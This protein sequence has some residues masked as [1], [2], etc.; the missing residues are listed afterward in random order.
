MPWVAVDPKGDWWGIRL[1]ADGIAEGLSVPVFG[2]LH[3]DLPLMPWMGATIASLIVDYNLTCVLDVSE[4]DEKEDL[5]LF[6]VDFM[7]TLYG[8]HGKTPSPRHIF[9]EEADAIIPQKPPKDYQDCIRWAAKLVRLGRSRGLGV[10]L[11]SQR[12]AGVDK[13]ALS[14][15][16][17]IIAMRTTGTLDRKAIRDWLEHHSDC[18]EIVDSLPKLEDGEAWICSPQWLKS[19]ERVRFRRR[20]TFD[21][22]ATPAWECGV[23]DQDFAEVDIAALALILAPDTTPVSFPPDPD[24][25]WD[26]AVPADLGQAECDE[27]ELLELA[28]LDA[29][30]KGSDSPLTT[31]EVGALVGLE[32]PSGLYKLRTRLTQLEAGGHVV[33]T[34][35]SRRGAPS[36]WTLPE[37]PD[38]VLVP[39][40]G[41]DVSERSDATVEA[42][43]GT[44]ADIELRET[45]RE[46]ERVEEELANAR[47]LIALQEAT[48]VDLA[49]AITALASAP[50]PTSGARGA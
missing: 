39:A 32:G 48:E 30:A 29:V 43:W 42:N 18:K 24:A 6:M 21:S 36:G 14:Q 41:H 1:A 45:R 19:F 38:G 22:G 20:R 10:T 23:S 11:V 35:L 27:K 15:V 3:G 9:F 2:G 16:D 46:L 25:G 49:E 40:Q 44:S 17:T 7:S 28:I 8:L 47:A 12:S 13:N 33:R 37:E 50:V 34:V 4:L 26:A 5:P 31:S